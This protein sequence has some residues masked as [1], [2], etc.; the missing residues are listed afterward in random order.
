M[1]HWTFDLV[2]SI[3]ALVCRVDFRRESLWISVVFDAKSHLVRIMVTKE[4]SIKFYVSRFIFWFKG[5]HVGIV[6]QRLHRIANS[7]VSSDFIVAHA[8]NEKVISK[9]FLAGVETLEVGDW[10]RLSLDIFE[11]YSFSG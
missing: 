1:T 4:F 9:E 6:N 7:V 5:F 8:A 11:D 3:I 10:T 2:V